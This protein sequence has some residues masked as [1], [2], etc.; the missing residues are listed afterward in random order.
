MLY[1]LCDLCSQSQDKEIKY[2]WV[3]CNRWCATDGV[4]QRGLIAADGVT[5]KGMGYSQD[6]G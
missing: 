4:L 6:V 2:L 3:D 1:F 5:H